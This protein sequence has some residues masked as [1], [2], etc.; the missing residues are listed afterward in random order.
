MY[1]KYFDYSDV[2][3]IPR[4]AI[5]N[6]RNDCDTSI[7]FGGMKFKIPVVPANM[8]SCIDV[9]LCKNLAMNDYFYIMHRFDV[10]QIEFIKTMKSKNLFTSISIGVNQD[11]YD[12]INKLIKENLIPNYITID[13]SHGHAIKM[14]KMLRFLKSEV[15]IDSF[16]IAGNICTVDGAEDLIEWG[17]DALKIGIAPGLSCSTYTETGFGSKN[18]QASIINEISEYVDINYSHKNIKIIADGGIREN[19]DIAIAMVMG[20]DMCMVGSL[21]A[22][23]SDSPAKIDGNGKKIYHGSASAHQSGK[24]NRIEGISNLMDVKKLTYLEEMKN[25]EEALQSA[26]SYSGGDNI[27]TLKT[28]DYIIK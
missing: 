13:I 24:T 17:A 28:V 7:E 15:K 14:E 6:S 25:I 8:E 2:N 12:L 16:I 11:S 4:K 22:G 23:L 1:K 3:L 19:K 27:E 5:V 9:K 21:F 18:I 10:D 26:I 20:A